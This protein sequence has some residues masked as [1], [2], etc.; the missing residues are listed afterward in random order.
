MLKIPLN[1]ANIILPSGEKFSLLAPEIKDTKGVISVS[2]LLDIKEFVGGVIEV[3]EKFN[4]KWGNYIKKHEDLFKIVATGVSDNQITVYPVDYSSFQDQTFK[5]SFVCYGYIEDLMKFPDLNESES[6]YSI[7]YEGMSLCFDSTTKTTQTRDF[8]GKPKEIHRAVDWDHT[9]SSLYFYYDGKYY[10][11]NVMLIQR[12]ETKQIDLIIDPDTPLPF[13]VYNAIKWPLTAFLSFGCGNNIAIR[14][15]SLIVKEGQKRRIY[16]GKRIIKSS[17]SNYIPLNDYGLRA[18]GILNKYFE[19]FNLFL[20]V[21]KILRISEA[22]TLF[23]FAKKA[24]TVDESIYLMLVSIEALAD[25]FKK[26]SFNELNSGYYMKQELFNEKIKNTKDV[27][28]KDFEFFQKSNEV[29][30]KKLVSAIAGI[31]KISK[32]NK[33]IYDLFKFAELQNHEGK[34]DFFN[35]LRNNAIHE[36]EINL[37][38]AN[39]FHNQNKL[40]LIFNE[41]IA[42]IMQYKFER[43]LSTE[44]RTKHVQVKKDYVTDYTRFGFN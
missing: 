44:E 41:I 19:S 20:F 1:T 37:P 35:S 2:G 30:F 29:E 5:V 13:K 7:G 14:E 9:N 11:I 17:N 33:K 4:M 36:G 31:N 22:I 3:V 40:E 27:F 6:L 32:T 38:E 23:N 26:S 10:N 39:A 28:M 42:N 16:S 34:A 18:N 25:R 12:K 24:R 15:E 21:E 43:Y 8:F